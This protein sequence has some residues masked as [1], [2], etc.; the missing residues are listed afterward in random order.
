M[1]VM[2]RALYEKL[3]NDAEM[4]MTLLPM[5]KSRHG[6]QQAKKN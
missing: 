4:R 6:S 3:V 2:P 1:V 5:T